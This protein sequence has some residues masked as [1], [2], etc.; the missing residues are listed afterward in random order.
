MSAA[1][2]STTAVRIQIAITL[3]EDLTVTAKQDMLAMV[4]TVLVRIF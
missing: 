1:R 4:L 3:R 2:V